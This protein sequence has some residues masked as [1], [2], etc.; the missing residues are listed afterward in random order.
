MTGGAK[1]KLIVVT[2]C[3]LSPILPFRRIL[4]SLTEIE[5]PVLRNTGAIPE[6]HIPGAHI[7]DVRQLIKAPRYLVGDGIRQGCR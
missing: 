2:T 7:F 1:N 3:H 5:N 4:S 6:N